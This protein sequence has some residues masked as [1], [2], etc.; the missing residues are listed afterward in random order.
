MGSTCGSVEASELVLGP[1]ASQKDDRI[2]E[3]HVGQT[4]M[5][6]QSQTQWC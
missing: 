5:F 3:L 4:Q 6:I 2:D 1:S